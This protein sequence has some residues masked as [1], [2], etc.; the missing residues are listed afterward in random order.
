MKNARNYS[1]KD[2]LDVLFSMHKQSVSFFLFEILIIIGLECNLDR[3]FVNTSFGVIR[4]SDSYSSS[5]FH[6]VLRP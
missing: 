3:L 6:L 1:I 2:A 5:K 4:N